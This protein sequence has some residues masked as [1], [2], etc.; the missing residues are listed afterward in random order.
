VF[1]FGFELR[2]LDEV[3]P[4]GRDQAT[5]HWFGIEAGGHQL[6]QPPAD[7][8]VVRLWEDVNV[9]T[10]KV[11]EPVPADLQ[12][13]IRSDR[14]QWARLHPGRRPTIPRRPP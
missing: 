10:R 14:T 2:P 3:T 11:L 8:Y 4:W 1:H 9:L 12:P 5:L 6:L 13:F 7:Y